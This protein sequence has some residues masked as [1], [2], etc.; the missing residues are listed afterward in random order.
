MPPI[1]ASGVVVVR[2]DDDSASLLVDEWSPAA[3]AA[4]ASSPY[5]SRRLLHAGKAAATRRPTTTT[6]DRSHDVKRFICSPFAA[7]FRTMSCARDAAVSV[8]DQQPTNGT[9]GAGVERRRREAMKKRPSLEQLL[10][11]EATPPPAAASARPDQRKGGKP[12]QAPPPSYDQV[13]SSRAVK[14]KHQK[15]QEPL[16]SPEGPF[17]AAVSGDDDGE[18]RT[19]TVPVKLEAGSGRHM[20]AKR[21]V[22]VLE[23]LR[24]CSRAPRINDEGKVAAGR[25]PGPGKAELFYHRPIPMGRRCRVQH[26]E[27][28]PYGANDLSSLLDLEQM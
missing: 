11:M 6:A 20:N 1:M 19:A 16:P 8:S 18:R 27:E 7:V 5:P 17:M 28:S 23:S 12:R 15:R 2:N 10:R 21:L 14:V 9:A 26:L 22:V 25:A 24:A 3:V 4:A 13:I